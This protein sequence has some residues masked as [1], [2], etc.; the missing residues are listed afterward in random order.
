MNNSH[1]HI[2][3]EDD[4]I[5]LLKDES[6]AISF[7][8]NEIESIKVFKRDLVT[9]DLICM[10]FTTE[11]SSYELNEEM[12]AWND[13]VETLPDVLTNCERV[14]KWFSKV[15]QTPFETNEIEIYSS[16]KIAL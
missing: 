4:S 8:V 15:T 7:R 5:I 2:K 12:K 16:N 9:E 13:F 14:E 1:F 3:I 11:N 6:L 10:E